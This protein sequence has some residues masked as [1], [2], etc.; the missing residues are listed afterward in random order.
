M[1]SKGVT[2]GRSEVTTDTN[3]IDFEHFDADEIHLTVTSETGGLL[4]LSEL[5]APGW[6]AYLNGEPVETHTVNGIFRGVIV[7][8]GESTVVFRYELRSLR[9]GLVISSISAIA[10]IG[11]A[12]WN[13]VPWLSRRRD[14][15]R[16]G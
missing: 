14:A 7:P 4:V 6:Q 15:R 9:V 11:I 8:V 10:L 1:R 5:D 2:V 16:N 13:L 12:I 3:T